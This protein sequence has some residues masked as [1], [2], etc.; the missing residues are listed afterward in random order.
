MKAK[1]KKEAGKKRSRVKVKDLSKPEKELT[2]KE[3]KKVKG[4]AMGDGS[5]RTFS[6]GSV[7]SIKTGVSGITDGTSNT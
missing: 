2:A 3:K 6:D 5:V 1:S 7:R 4:G